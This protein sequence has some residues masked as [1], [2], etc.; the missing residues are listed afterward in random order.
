MTS[1]N[2]VPRSIALTLAAYRVLLVVCPRALRQGYGNDML[3]VVR[4]C[5]L[6]AYQV[7][8]ARGV[9]QLWLPLLGDV[10]MGAILE[11]LS[12]LV[13]Q[14]KEG[15]QMQRIRSSVV[16]V[17]CAYIAFVVVGI[18]FQKMTEYSDF[19]EAG[20]AHPIL[21]LAF[22]VVVGGSAV[23][24]L[25]VLAGGVPLALAALRYALAAK[26]FGIVWLLAAPLFAFALLIGY[27]AIALR[28]TG[29]TAR[30]LAA[31]G[32]VGM[33]VLGAVISTAGVSLAISRSELSPTLVRFSRI[34]ALITTA[35]MAVMCVATVVWT[36]GLRTD[37][38]QLFTG[39]NGFKGTST[40]IN[41]LIIVV[42]MV[43]A[44]VAASLGVLRSFTPPHA[45][46]QGAARAAVGN[47]G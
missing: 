23:A 47:I 14:W 3:Q 40:A 1:L 32:L 8:R 30:D 4:Q 21:G 24:L 11:Q 12:V 36:L 27:G 19:T 18:G 42:V 37:V 22:S 2:R 26:R 25:A 43:V 6:D 39:N 13:T 38:P 41:A 45:P 15:W 29:G 28:V 10:L 35:A 7:R 44:T 34:P 9:A 31:F 16:M 33:L 20:Q 17:F 5:C 46:G